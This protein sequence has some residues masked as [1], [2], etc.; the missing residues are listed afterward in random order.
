M[1]LTVE[2]IDTETK[3]LEDRYRIRSEE[4][5]ELFNVHVDDKRILTLFTE[6][7][8]VM[9]KWVSELQKANRN[10]KNKYPLIVGMCVDRDLEY[11]KKGLKDNPYDIIAL[12]TGSNCLIYSLPDGVHCG[13]GYG[14]NEVPKI[15]KEFLSDCNVIFVGMD[16]GD[17]AK[18][19]EKN[20]ELKV[21]RY[22]DIRCLGE[23][24]LGYWMRHMKEFSLD[25]ITKLM[26]DKRMDVE[27]LNFDKWRDFDY[28]RFDINKD[29][30]KYLTVDA[31]FLHEMA[32]K[33]VDI[34]TE[35]ASNSK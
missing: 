23:K 24:V 8:S 12:C 10:N 19:L 21:E 18:K 3:N 28:R 26:L 30:V 35:L 16:I 20:Q 13:G 17:V 34:T 25:Q 1:E 33:Y 32:T 22:V 31:Y 9:R 5:Y 7:N 2:R 29:Y 14:S 6:C 27:R 11:M 4:R 15:L